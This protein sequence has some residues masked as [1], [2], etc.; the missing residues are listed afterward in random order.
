MSNYHFDNIAHQPPFSTLARLYLTSFDT[1][2]VRSM[3]QY[4][5][6]PLNN[7]YEGKYTFREY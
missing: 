6:V 7:L 4:R 1:L 5:Q 2:A 3:L